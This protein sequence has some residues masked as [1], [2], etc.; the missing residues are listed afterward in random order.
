MKYTLFII[1]S[2]LCLLAGCKSAEKQ[3]TEVVEDQ[4]SLGPQRHVMERYHLRDSIEGTSIVFTIHREADST[5][6][7]V[8]D[9]F[10]DTYVDN[11]YQLTISKGGA[12]FFSHRFTKQSF[13]N[14]SDGLRS[15]TIFDGFRYVGRED[16][17]IQFS[18]CLSE[19]DSDLSVPYLLSVGPDGSYTI[20]PDNTPDLD[21]PV[22]E[23]GV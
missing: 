1:A 23:D 7:V 15:A 17:K 9:E 2:S 18:V 3:E 12:E 8:K 20:S 22:E 4:I 14:L 6:A 11:Y 16:G 19:P 13:S 10:G 5:L 21:E